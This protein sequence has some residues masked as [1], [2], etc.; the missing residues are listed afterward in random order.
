MNWLNYH[1]LYYFYVIAQ[2]GSVTKATKKLRLA[3]STLSTQLKQFEDV[4]GH[5]LFERK[6]KS[7]FLTDMGRQVLEYAHEI[8]SLG[9]ELKDSLS[10]RDKLGIVKVQIGI[11]DSIPKS[12]S[13]ALLDYI[14]SIENVAVRLE[15]G[16]EE[17]L[18][19]KLEDHEI[20]LLISDRKPEMKKNRRL[21]CKEL[22]EMEYFFGAHR[23][24]NFE[25]LDQAVLRGNFVFRLP[26]DP[27]L[28]VYEA[29]VAEGKATSRVLAELHDAEIHQ[30]L[31]KSGK[32][33]GAI[34]DSA[35]KEVSGLVKLNKKPAFKE[36]LWMISARRKLQ[37][38][39]AQKVWNNFHMSDK[40]L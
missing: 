13:E 1:H 22:H 2:E 8:F 27:G 7:I 9:Q 20:D 29:A 10:D 24:L 11:I 25:T 32:A 34:P 16:S 31:I 26:Y 15:E 40:M 17:S 33:V 3:Q 12:I 39:I 38:P 19:E 14:F 28:D 18:I 37:N 4:I 23:N 36:V 5:E 21:I 30:R 6:G 35:F